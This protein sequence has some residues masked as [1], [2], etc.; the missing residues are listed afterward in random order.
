MYPVREANSVPRTPIR[1]KPALQ[2]AETAWNTE[3]YSPCPQPKSPTNRVASTAAPSSSK[4]S[5][6]S[7][8]RLIR[9]SMPPMRPVPEDSISTRRSYSPIFLR[10]NMLN[11]VMTVMNPTPPIWMSRMMTICPNVDQ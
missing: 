8:M 4:N 7:K 10:R 2:K 5:V 9:C 1:S 3:K 6:N 11:M